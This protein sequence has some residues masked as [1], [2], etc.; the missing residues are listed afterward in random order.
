[1]TFFDPP[2]KQPEHRCK[3]PMPL[4]AHP[5]GWRCECGKAYVKELLPSR[6]INPGEFPHQWR[7]APEHDG[8]PA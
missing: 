7:R 1:V 8:E 2:P 6:D 4:M 5:N 3:L